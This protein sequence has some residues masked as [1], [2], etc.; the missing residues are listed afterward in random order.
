LRRLVA[1]TGNPGKLTEMRRRLADLGAEVVSPK[2]IGI[3]LEVEEDGDTFEANASLK[4]L[5]AASAAGTAAIADDSGLEVDALDGRPGVRS[6]RYGGPGLD[7]AARNARLLAEMSEVPDGRRTARFRCAIAVADPDGIVETFTGSLEG[8]IARTPEGEHGFGYDPVFVPDGEDRTL[9][10]LG[11][12]VKSRISHRAR[13][14]D[15]LARWLVRAE[16]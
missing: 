15:A 2:E 5:A 13:A 1:A 11:P 12:E 7:D 9:A 4:A 6:A 8:R 3:D 14:L 16:G 10:V